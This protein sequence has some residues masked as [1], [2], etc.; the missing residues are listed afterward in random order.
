MVQPNPLSVHILL[1][2]AL[3]VL[4]LGCAPGG[5]DGTVDESGAVSEVEPVELIESG[6]LRVPK[7]FEVTVFAQSVG[8]GRHI[9]V[10]DNG[11]IYVRL[12]EQLGQDADGG[13]IAALR[14]EDG[15]GKAERIE[16]FGP[17]VGTGV[18]I[19]DGW[20]WFSSRTEVWK[21]ELPTDGELVP[22]TEPVLVVTGFPEQRSHTAKALAFD[23]QGFLYVNSGAPSNACQTEARTAGS[24]G[25]DPCPQL[26]R[27]GGVWRFPADQVGMDQGDGELFTTGLRNAVG[28][29]WSAALGRVVAGTHGRDQ[30]DTL[31]PEHFTAE[32]NTELP[33]EE[34]IALEQGADY[35]WPYA[36]WD[37]E[38]GA[39]MMNPEYGG[40]GETEAESGR[41][42]P[43]TVALPAHWAP[44]AA[45]FYDS[46]GIE[47]SFP[48]E[49][50][51]GA[52]VAF[53]GSWNRAPAPQ[54]GYNVVFVPLV[55]GALSQ[56]W[57][58]FADGFAGQDPLM[59]PG[60][61]AHRPTGLAVGPDGS[62]YIGD[63]VEGR[64]WRVRWVG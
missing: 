33:A 48:Q 28:L 22:T 43:P 10:R 12:R 44:N 60:D 3:V 58:V 24:P 1:V 59:S 41:F 52:F 61:A 38:K 46:E 42:A 8:R 51:G 19:Q 9:A 15:D 11:D 21:V 39:R 16:S 56:D 50:Q 55:D 25:L 57:R 35:G 54:G 5:T 40:D 26:E 63:S 64:I 23:D 36:Y 37:Q 27:G 29:G 4:L 32:Q 45:V 20:L 13:G 7:G 53:H 49:Y 31:W 6:G 17:E 34:L 30:L 62:L 18:L 2:S 47:Q 14:D